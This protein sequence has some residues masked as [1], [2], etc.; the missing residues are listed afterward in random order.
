MIELIATINFNGIDFL[1]FARTLIENGQNV[2]KPIEVPIPFSIREKLFAD[3][4]FDDRQKAL[5][6]DDSFL[7]HA[8]I[9]V[10]LLNGYDPDPEGV[11]RID[12]VIPD[13]EYEL[14]KD[15]T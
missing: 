6:R 14:Y 2:F 11:C 1:D 9:Q 3:L 8:R 12:G 13:V 7:E 5:L 10:L 15:W 4:N